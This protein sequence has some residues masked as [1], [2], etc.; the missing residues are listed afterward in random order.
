MSTFLHNLA[1][2]SVN[3]SETIGSSQKVETGA[4]MEN[5][6]N[7]YQPRYAKGFKIVFCLKIEV[8]FC[9]TLNVFGR[10]KLI[11]SGIIK[12]VALLE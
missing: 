7:S 10:H 8:G 2:D 6:T 11:R 3:M 12:G 5:N 4:T 1:V 9:S